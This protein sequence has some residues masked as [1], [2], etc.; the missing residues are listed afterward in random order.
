MPL[1]C[2]TSCNNSTSYPCRVLIS[3]CHCTAYRTVLTWALLQHCYRVLYSCPAQRSCNIVIVILIV[4]VIV[5]VLVLVIVIVIGCIMLQA[6]G[7]DISRERRENIAPTQMASARDISAKAA[8]VWFGS[9][10]TSLLISH[11]VGQ[12]LSMH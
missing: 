6:R 5:L 1:C 11:T 3:M 4:N 12:V 9:T 8:N 10:S 2:I 7:S